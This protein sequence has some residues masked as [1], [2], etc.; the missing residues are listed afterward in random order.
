MSQSRQIN[1]CVTD[2]C[3]CGEPEQYYAPGMTKYLKEVSGG[4]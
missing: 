4:K 2:D 3:H 1:H